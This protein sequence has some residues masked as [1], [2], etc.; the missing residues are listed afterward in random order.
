MHIFFTVDIYVDQSYIP[1]A[2]SIAIHDMI[3]ET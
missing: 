1:R 2:L 3:M